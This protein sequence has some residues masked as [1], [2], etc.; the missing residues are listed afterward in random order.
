[1]N[2]AHPCPRCFVARPISPAKDH[3]YRDRDEHWQH[4]HDELLAPAIGAAGYEV[5][6][7]TAAGS[8]VIH[9]AIIGHLHDC[10][11]VVADFSTLNPN[12]LFEAGIRTAI[13]KPL[14]IVAE[15]GTRLP[16]DT[17]SVN[18]VFYDPD[19]NSWDLRAKIDELKAHITKTDTDSRLPF[20]RGAS[21]PA[22]AGSF[23]NDT[24][25]IKTEDF[26]SSPDP[27]NECRLSWFD[28]AA[29][30]LP[31]GHSTWG[32]RPV[33]Q[34]EPA[35]DT[36]RINTRYYA[37]EEAA[38]PVGPSGA[39]HRDGA[40]IRHRR[41]SVRSTVERGLSCH[42]LGA[43]RRVRHGGRESAG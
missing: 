11:L 12:V 21:V 6:P 38:V 18:T 28:S 13:G 22:C 2:A 36:M 32:G 35:T 7:P 37:C 10:E 3:D 30:R 5:V 29:T 40:G 15:H 31:L 24:R 19:L 41:G 17:N 34:A 27:V 1:M 14:V 8:T 42:R 33:P 39:R 20:P 25:L 16:F 4:V 26:R 43:P 9:A 23:P